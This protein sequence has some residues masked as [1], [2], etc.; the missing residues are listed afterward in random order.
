MEFLLNRHFINQSFN[1]IRTEV[2]REVAGDSMVAPRSGDQTA[3]AQPQ[4]AHA[5]NG[6]FRLELYF[7]KGFL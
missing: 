5:S 7:V 6:I 1:T 3:P 4:G 2:A